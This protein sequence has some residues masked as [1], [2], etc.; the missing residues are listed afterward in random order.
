[1]S[2]S[3]SGVGLFFWF[4]LGVAI[5]N[6]I[7]DFLTVPGVY[8]VVGIIISIPV[9]EALDTVSIALSYLAVG[10]IAIAGAFEY[11]DLT[12]FGSFLELFPLHTVILVVAY[13][14]LPRTR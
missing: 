13:F 6:D 9:S 2:Q 5:L 14:F 12:Y 10:P 3:Q 4:A 7:V 8:S 1:M 11:I